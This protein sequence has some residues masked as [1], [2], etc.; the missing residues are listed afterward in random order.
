MDK[1]KTQRNTT[2]A[3]RRYVFHED[4]TGAELLRGAD[5]NGQERNQTAMSV[6][7]A[8]SSAKKMTE[9]EMAS[10]DRGQMPGV[11]NDM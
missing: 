4:S 3:N 1:A 8:T 7:P 9:L 2:L 5:E 10:T 11:S 6:T